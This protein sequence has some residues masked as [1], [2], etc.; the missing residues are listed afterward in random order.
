ML[1]A[2]FDVPYVRAQVGH[3]DPAAT[4]G[5]YA[6]VIERPDRDRLRAEMRELLGDGTTEASE[7]LREPQ[8][9]RLPSEKDPRAYPVRSGCGSMGDL[10]VGGGL[11]QCG[12]SEQRLEGGHGGVA[13]VVAEDVLVEVDLE[14]RVA[15]AAVG[16]VHPGLEV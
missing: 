10:V 13:A 5:V 3:R 14:V 2:G 12:E 15:D 16:A 11:V 7:A 6:Q 4:L 1:A 8:D 9:V